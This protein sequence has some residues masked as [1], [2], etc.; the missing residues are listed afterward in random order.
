MS[1]TE[2]QNLTKRLSDARAS[3]SEIVSDVVAEQEAVLR[4]ALPLIKA[5]LARAADRH[6]ALHAAIANS[7]D[8]FVAP[9]THVFHGI[10]VG[11]TKGKG[12]IEFEDE[13]QVIKNIHR[14]LPGQVDTLI[15]IT[16]SVMKTALKNLSVAD[17]KSIGC[18]VEE[19]GDQIVIHATDKAV[20]KTVKALLKNATEQAI[21]EAV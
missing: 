4:R 14:K 19:T 16:E 11:L 18:T 8:L 20:D 9:R 3:V 7:Q 13:D 10:K 17:L 1:I 12:K 6:A 15:N 21:E 5:R 2:I